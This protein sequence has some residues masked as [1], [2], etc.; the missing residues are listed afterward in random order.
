F[1]GSRAPAVLAPKSGSQLA[2]LARE[3]AATG[4]IHKSGQRFSQARALPGDPRTDQETEHPQTNEKQEVNDGDRPDAAADQFL[5]AL[6]GGINE[7]GKKNGKEEENQ[8]ASRRIEKT[9]P[10]GEQQG[11]E[12]N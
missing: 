4:F 9:H 11:R 10:D 6:D 2:D 3:L 8:R 5:Q 1:L 7:I 12:Q